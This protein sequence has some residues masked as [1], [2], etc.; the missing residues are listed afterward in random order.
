MSSTTRPWDRPGAGQ[1]VP[2]QKP[3]YDTVL[4]R[5][6]LLIETKDPSGLC[7]GARGQAAELPAIEVEDRPRP[8]SLNS[9][10]EPHR[11]RRGR[12]G[13]PERGATSCVRPAATKPR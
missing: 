5:H 2:T 7:T 6:V 3:A 9:T 12:A 1:P 10:P 13:C 8:H 11:L 4:D